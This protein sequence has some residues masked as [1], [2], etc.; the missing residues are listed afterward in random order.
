MNRL[1]VSLTLLFMFACAAMA[2]IND[3]DD[4]FTVI[5]D[6]FNP[7][8]ARDSLKSNHKEVPKGLSIWTIDNMFG[9]RTA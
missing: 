1:F 9:D 3:Y 7:N 8:R 4:G 6:T 2:Q 5:D